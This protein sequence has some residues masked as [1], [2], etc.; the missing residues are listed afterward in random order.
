[1]LSVCLSL[2]TLAGEITDLPNFPPF[3]ESWSSPEL[4]VRDCVL[5]DADSDGKRDVLVAIEEGGLGKLVLFERDGAGGL[6]EVYRT[7]PGEATTSPITS[8][9]TGDTDG[10]GQRELLALTGSTTASVHAW[11]ATG[12]DTFAARG[13]VAVE[14]GPFSLDE[15]PVRLRLG[16][17]DADGRKELV[18]AISSGARPGLSKVFVH[19]H[20]GVVGANAYTSVYAHETPWTIRDFALGDSDGNG[21][22][23]ILLT[24]RSA[25]DGVPHFRM[26]EFASG[27]VVDTH[28]VTLAGTCGSLFEP[29]LGD[30]DFDGTRELM[31]S[32]SMDCPGDGF[33]GTGLFVLKATGDHTYDIVYRDA[34]LAL[35]DVDGRARAAVGEFSCLPFP[36]PVVSG[37]PSSGG[38][39][40]TQIYSW[41]PEGYDAILAAPIPTDVVHGL[42]LR[43]FDGDGAPDLITAEAGSRSGLRLWEQHTWCYGSGVNPI[44]SLLILGGAPELGTLLTLGVDDPTGSHG[45]GS[46]PFVV[47][48]T[49]PDP[50]FPDG[51]SL[52]GFGMAAGLSAGELLVSFTTPH[53]IF[54]GLPWQ[55]ATFPS[56]VE[57]PIRDL[58]ILSGL[59]LYAQG[60]LFDPSLH[61]VP[62]WGLA[63]G[64]ELPIQ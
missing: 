8:V 5:G 10:D 17:L 58:A 23:E 47:L 16:D 51:T 9:A 55:G 50:N 11:E 56:P 60:V 62:H 22:A 34:P 13:A 19:E 26:L 46:I 7:P 63:E 36:T 40:G 59:S 29:A 41:H 39:T 14:A 15:A 30:F 35:T 3:P 57:I 2:A 6:A 52:P 20:D 37:G 12:D 64:M 49:T 44:E 54:S 33:E 21:R 4:V 38:D 25:A 42:A 53:A 61:G 32:A 18:F 27:G 45:I 48:A 1:M 28:D 31:F 24:E 43:D